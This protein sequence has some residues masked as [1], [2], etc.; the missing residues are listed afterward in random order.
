V[1]LRLVRAPP[2]G[3]DGDVLAPDVQLLLALRARVGAGRYDRLPV[4][5]ARRRFRRENLL[6]AG[7]LAPVATVR[8]LSVPGAQGALPA[9]HYVPERRGPHP[10]LVY[11]HGGGFVLGDLDSYDAACRTLCHHAGAQVLSVAYRLAPEHR[12]PA[13]ADDARAAFAWA[14]AHALALGALPTR[15]AVGGD[16]AGANL[17]AVVALRTARDGG[18]APAAQLL[19][20]PSVDRTR[21]W[22]SLDLFAEG[23]LLTRAEIEWFHGHYTGGRPEAPREPGV[24]PLLA[25]DLSGLA[26]AVVVTAAFDPLRDEGEA[27][28]AAL[29][30]AGTPTVLRRMR[31]LVQGFV[32]MAGVSRSARRALVETARLLAAELEGDGGAA[33]AAP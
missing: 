12:Y 4:P 18:P 26:R 11:F 17:A 19:V 23:F 15:V 3:R 30:A 13:A 28:A 27:Y 16:S 7:P 32:N 8:D 22:R 1:Q 33:E 21:A 25:S 20:Y 14:A 31:G 10:L 5:E 24:S 29:A 6:H 9:R 2:L